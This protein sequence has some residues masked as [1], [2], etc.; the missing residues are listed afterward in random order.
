MNDDEQKR[1][2]GVIFKHLNQAFGELKLLEKDT[3]DNVI[4][5]NFLQL[6]GSVYMDI[7]FSTYKNP[8]EVVQMISHHLQNQVRIV[9]NR[10]KSEEESSVGQVLH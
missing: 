2:V 9:N 1:Y 8:L 4:L 3:E 7:M 6:L 5:N 10:Q